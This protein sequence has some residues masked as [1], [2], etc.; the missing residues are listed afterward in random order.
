MGF[1][2]L[3]DDQLKA[4]VKSLSITYDSLGK[5]LQR[6]TGRHRSDAVDELE[7]VDRTLTAFKHEQAQRWR[8]PS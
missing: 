7:L 6:L 1:E 2:S 4:V 8:V 3:D 5:K